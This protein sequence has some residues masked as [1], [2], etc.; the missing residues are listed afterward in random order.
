M[1]I[2]ELL[3]EKIE[4]NFNN[5]KMGVPTVLFAYHVTN[6]RNFS[7]TKNSIFFCD[8]PEDWTSPWM[9]NPPKI[10]KLRIKLDCPYI[11]LNSHKD[12][13]TEIL[14]LAKKISDNG[15]DS[16][17]WTPSK[18]IKA[19]SMPRQGLLMYGALNKVTLLGKIKPK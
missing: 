14:P 12:F 16:I 19:F 15:F 18:K 9:K 6:K 7:I 4:I 2:E 3:N 1:K 11:F 17:I 8:N 13:E 5:I 10:Y